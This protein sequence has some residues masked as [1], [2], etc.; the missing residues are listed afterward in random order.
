M[1]AAQEAAGES[2]EET[3]KWYGGFLVAYNAVMA[4]TQ[5]A[6]AV[7]SW[8]N[9][10]KV[11]AHFASAASH[12]AA[13]VLAATQL[14]GGSAAGASAPAA[15]PTSTFTPAESVAAPSD[16]GPRETTIHNSYLMSD[17]EASLA[18]S[19]ERAKWQRERSHRVTRS[20]AVRH[21]V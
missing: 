15:A 10:P 2:A 21:G 13:A 17:S 3:K 16:S 9:W 11:V 12:T 18:R 14:G 5:V 1:I 8:G 4:A 20:T 6:Q 19:L 7:G